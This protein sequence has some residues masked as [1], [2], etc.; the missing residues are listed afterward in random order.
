MRQLFF[1]ALALI[2]G[3]MPASTALAQTVQ[4]SGSTFAFPIISKWSQAYQYARADGGDFVPNDAEIDYEPIGSLGGFLRLAQPEID[5]AATEAPVSP[6]ELE[7]RGL[8]QFPVV[9]GGIVPVLN[10]DGV[11]AGKVKLTGELLADIYLGKI[12]DWSDP[13]IQAINPDLQLPKLRIQVIHRKDGSGSTLAWTSFLWGASEEWKSKYGADTLVSWPLGTGVEGSRG[14]VRAVGGT[15]GAIGYVEYGQV[16]RARLSY[17]LVR[18]KSG[19]FVAP[20]Q[21]A[22]QAAG[23]SADWAQARDFHL[24][25]IDAPGAES[26]P[27]TTATFIVM[28]RTGRSGSRTMRTLRFFQ[29]ALEKGAADAEALGYVPLPEALVSQVKAYWRTT[30]DF[31]S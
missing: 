1:T 17:A 2:L 26:Y 23:A 6:Q 28:H 3:S 12:Q 13:A 14:I 19:R 10:L 20:G 25:L 11:D 16:Q 30:F 31:G 8:A 15:K 7:K 29:F 24:S 27:I 21:K 18:N 5:F 22:F 9:I 4:G